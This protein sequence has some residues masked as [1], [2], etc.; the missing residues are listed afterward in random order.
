MD[1]SYDDHFHMIFNVDNNLICKYI[2]VFR[3]TVIE[4]QQK[5]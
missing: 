2:Y 4:F 5:T 3:F 1:K